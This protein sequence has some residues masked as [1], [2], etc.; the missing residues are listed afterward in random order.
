MVVT[1]PP[2]RNVITVAASSGHPSPPTAA[3]CATTITESC[4]A[5]RNSSSLAAKPWSCYMKGALVHIPQSP[6][7][8]S[9]AFEGS[10]L[11]PDRADR[12]KA[13]LAALDGSREDWS[14]IAEA[15]AA[16]G[17]VLSRLGTVT[18]ARLIRHGY[19]LAM[20]NLHTILDF[21][22]LPIPPSERFVGLV[23]G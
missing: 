4:P 6:Y 22:L 15:S 20:A 21:P 18:S 9:K 14:V 13:V 3:G 7:V 19:V 16:V 8:V 10:T 1:F 23:G 17:T 11:W 12:A 5:S 2:W